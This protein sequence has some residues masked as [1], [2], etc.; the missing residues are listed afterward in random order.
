MLASVIKHMQ[1]AVS[2]KIFIKYILPTKFHSE[3]I[4]MTVTTAK[5]INN[6]L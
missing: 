2:L 3:S 5:Y 4:D 1:N 6:I